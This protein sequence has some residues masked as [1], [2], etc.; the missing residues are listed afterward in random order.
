MDYSLFHSLNNFAAAHDSFEDT[1]R[2][3][4]QISEIL[5]L[6][7]LVALF[8]IGHPDGRRAALAAGVSAGL[9]LLVAHFLAG[10]VD[11]PRPFVDHPS[12]HLFVKHAADPGFPSDHATAAFA[13][14]MAVWLRLR[15]LG[16]LALVL[17]AVLAL[18]RVAIGVHYPADVVAG[19][20][21]GI[22]A[23]LA[24]WAPPMRG[25]LDALADR[26]G[27][28]PVLRAVLR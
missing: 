23:A 16:A 5:F 22:T 20:A 17:A 4:A 25:R 18:A 9:A 19:A 3:Y 8:A 7:G 28:L 12:A 1:L 14:A 13:I 26:L 11:R 10:A 24:L 2:S 21:I 27:G 15:V 6:A